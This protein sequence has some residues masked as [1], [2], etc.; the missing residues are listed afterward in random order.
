MMSYET[1]ICNSPLTSDKYLG[2]DN[3]NSIKIVLTILVKEPLEN[4]KLHVKLL[5][6]TSFNQAT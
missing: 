6:F 3:A 1:F 2:C 4:I 5:G